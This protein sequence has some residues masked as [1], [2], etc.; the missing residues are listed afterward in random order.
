L[1]KG[2]TRHAAP[3]IPKASDRRAYGTAI[4][5]RAQHPVNLTRTCNKLRSVD[6]FTG[7]VS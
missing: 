4:A 3:T 6:W 2:G 1:E 7:E 5:I